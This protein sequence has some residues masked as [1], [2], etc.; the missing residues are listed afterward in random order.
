MQTGDPQTRKPLAMSQ[1]PRN[2]KLAAAI[3][4]LLVAVS[5]V[6]L[7]LP[8]AR[9]A[10]EHPPV[11]ALAILPSDARLQRDRRYATVRSIRS[12]LVRRLREI[13][14]GIWQRG[15]DVR[16]RLPVHEWQARGPPE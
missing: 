4:A 5:A 8:T 7:S 15:L 1:L 13:R 6:G 14:V 12:R 2:N 9:G 11:I 16:P 10:P 3:A